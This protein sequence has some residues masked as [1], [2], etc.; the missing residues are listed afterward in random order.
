GPDASAAIPSPTP[1]RAFRTVDRVLSENDQRLLTYVPEDLK[2]DCLPLD[3]DEPIQG[4]L[5]AL[6]CRGSDVEVLYE[7]FPTRDLMDQAFQVNVNNRAIPHGECA[8]D[9]QA[10]SRYS[11]G[12]EP[13]GRV[14]C[15]TVEPSVNNVP[16]PAGPPQPDQSHI[17]WT[18]DNSS[19]YAHAVRNDLG[20]LSLYDWWLSGAGPVLSNSDAKATEKDL[21]ASLGPQLRNGSYVISL[22][23]HEVER[24]DFTG[25]FKGP[26]GGT[27]AIRLSDGTYELGA[28]GLVVESGRALLQKPNAIVF[29]PE[30]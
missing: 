5:A 6:V 13:A 27:V 1:A 17:E 11:I 29:D 3:R 9:H 16:H 7:L 21:P 26:S 20:D 30:R 4:E 18:D 28:N 22:T 12:G 14:S 15:Y 25:L 24:Y 8:T 19:I 10:V 2:G 23:P